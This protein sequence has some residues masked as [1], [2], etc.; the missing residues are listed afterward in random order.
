MQHAVWYELLPY[1]DLLTPPVLSALGQRD[2]GLY[3]AVTPDRIAGIADAV[4][5]CMDR[6]LRVG[7][8][9]MVEKEHGRWPSAHNLDRFRA[10]VSEVRERL[11][12]TPHELVIDLEPPIDAMP[13]L[14]ALDTNT[15]VEHLRRGLPRA[16]EDAFVE[17]V[18]TFHADDMET[19]SAIFPLVLGD[20]D[21]KGWQRFFGTPVDTTPTHRVTAMLYTSI[22]EGFGRGRLSRRDTVAILGHA[23]RVA[24]R[25]YGSRA[26]VSVGAIDVGAL[27]DEPTYR[28]VEE[29]REDVG[30]TK[31]AGIEHL[32]LF[33]LCGAI[34]RAPIEPWLD[35]LVETEARSVPALTP[36]AAAACALVWSVSRMMRGADALLSNR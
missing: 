24:R 27:G 7:V 25:R 1:D 20:G 9:P 5:V 21:N 15:I 10:F 34:R 2:I 12:T 32:V 6:G 26:S 30:V 19:L 33:S 16:A 23:A 3:I 17:L 36:A 13:A 11:H 18:E 31:G 22:I 28:S 14:M 29:L 4:H 35:A 8:W